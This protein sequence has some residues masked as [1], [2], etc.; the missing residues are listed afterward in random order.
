LTSEVRSTIAN[1]GRGRTLQAMLAR[2]L[3]LC[4]TSA[5]VILPARA[6]VIVHEYALQGSLEDNYGGPALTAYGGEITALGYV[7]AAGQGLSLTS[8][9]LNPTNYSI[10]LSFRVDSIAGYRKLID[11]NGLST[12]DGLYQR[13]GRLAFLGGASTPTHDFNPNADVHLTLTRDA[14]TGLVSTYV[15]GEFRF[16]FTDTTGTATLGLMQTLTFFLD[17][18]VTGGED[19]T[20]GR[21][22]YLRIF[23]GALTSTEVSALLAA[24]PPLAIP[25]PGTAVLLA[26]GGAMLFLFRRARR[27]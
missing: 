8:P 20:S 1:A 3:L 24:G 19:V 16:S 26:A 9:K 10:E 14:A 11:F 22:N 17:D 15:D 25:E 13:T 21:L 2:A 7:F 6:A 18:T 5:L 27:R 4:V 23:D 12:D